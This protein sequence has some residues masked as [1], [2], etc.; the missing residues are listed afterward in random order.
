M[1]VRIIE[2]PREKDLEGVE[3]DKLRP[4]TVRDV[5]SAIGTWLIVQGYAYPEMRS[6]AGD[7]FPAAQHGH[8]ERFHGHDRRKP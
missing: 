6:S 2:S 8:E 4:G 5:S 7:E 3:L 1:R